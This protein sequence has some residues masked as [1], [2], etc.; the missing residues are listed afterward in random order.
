MYS[1]FPIFIKVRLDQRHTRWP[2]TASSTGLPHLLLIEHNLVPMS[3]RVLETGAFLVQSPIFSPW[4][5]TRAFVFRDKSLLAA[6]L[7]SIMNYIDL[8]NFLILTFLLVLCEL[9][10]KKL[11]SLCKKSFLCSPVQEG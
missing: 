5:P 8:S 10:L 6:L 3:W 9:S 11:I 2:T 1:F 4:C 7:F